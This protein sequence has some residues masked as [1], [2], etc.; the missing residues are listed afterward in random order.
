MSYLDKYTICMINN[1]Q[2]SGSFRFGSRLPKPTVRAS[3]GVIPVAPLGNTYRVEVSWIFHM[4]DCLYGKHSWGLWQIAKELG[5]VLLL[6]YFWSLDCNCD[7]CHG[8][9]QGQNSACVPSTETIL[10]ESF[11][12]WPLSFNEQN[13]HG[14]HPT[15]S[16]FFRN[17][18][19]PQH[20]VTKLNCVLKLRLVSHYW[21]QL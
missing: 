4:F 19:L 14:S 9:L 20:P 8:N 13:P 3:R 11:H 16:L 15:T 17:S 1:H 12:C 2:T 21:D 5:L 7:P 18:L 6:I 10:E